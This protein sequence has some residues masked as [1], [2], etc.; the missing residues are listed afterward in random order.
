MLSVASVGGLLKGVLAG[1]L[2][3]VAKVVAEEVVVHIAEDNATH[4]L[5]AMAM[6]RMRSDIMTVFGPESSTFDAIM[7]TG[8]DV[9]HA[10]RIFDELC[11]ADYIPNLQK[12]HAAAGSASGH[13]DEVVFCGTSMTTSCRDVC[14]LLRESMFVALSDRIATAL[15][16]ISDGPGPAGGGGGGGASASSL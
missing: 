13:H 7:G 3:L 10:R 11:S 2:R 8:A 1:G 5:T 6:G 12:K 9:S 4:A 15:H 14:H 16:V